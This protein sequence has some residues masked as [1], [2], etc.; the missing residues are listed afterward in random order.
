MNTIL[1][2][3]CVVIALGLLCR[4]LVQSF[5]KWLLSRP[6]WRPFAWINFAVAAAFILWSTAAPDW[7]TRVWRLTIFVVGV[8]ALVKGFSLWVFPNWSKSLTEKVMA[9]YWLFALPTSLAYLAL[10]LLMLSSD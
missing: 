8:S 10:S 1:A 4:P 3:V 2:V 7:S 6:S 9:R 5:S